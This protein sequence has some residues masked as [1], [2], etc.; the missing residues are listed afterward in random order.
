[1]MDV[2]PPDE[3]LTMKELRQGEVDIDFI[4]NTADILTEN[5][6][7]DFVQMVGEFGGCLGLFLGISLV[8]IYE[9]FDQ[10]CR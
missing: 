6:S 7:Y 10:L 8:S 1:M 2:Q 5:Q 3:K 9:F 4:E